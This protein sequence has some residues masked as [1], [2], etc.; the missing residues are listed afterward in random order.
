MKR[1]RATLFDFGGTLLEEVSFDPVAGT[2]AMLKLANNPRDVTLDEARRVAEE[3][4]SFVD[5]RRL[6]SLL[7]HSIHAFHRL[8]FE[9]LGITFDLSPD[10]LILEFWKAAVVMRPEPGVVESIHALPSDIRLGVISN[11]TTGEPAVRYELARHGLAERFEF[12]MGSADY[13]VRKPSPL[14]FKTALGKLD[15]PAGD[16]WYVGDDETNDVSGAK[17]CGI[18]SVWYNP[19]G[20]PA[21]QA[22]PDAFFT[23][24][25]R[26]RGLIEDG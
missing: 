7:E 15:L 6:D 19:R 22:T 1:P 16:V 18:I 9:R 11:A 20:N 25:H 13:G 14:L 8:L 21:N 3:I 5:P 24:W 26:F 12:I 2:L 10:E 17:S 23:S 4:K